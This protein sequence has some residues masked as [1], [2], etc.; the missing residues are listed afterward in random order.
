MILAKIPWTGIIKWGPDILVAGKTASAEIKKWLQKRAGKGGERSV[1]GFED[2]RRTIEELGR[3]QDAQ[4]RSLVE[5]VAQVQLQAK[6]LKII[7]Q[8][9]LAV[10][11]VSLAALALSVFLLVS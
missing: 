6:T 3:L 9:L 2:V 10:A 7:N 11:M 8:R 5:V 4:A 1:E